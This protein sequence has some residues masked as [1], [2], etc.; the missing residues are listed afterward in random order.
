MNEGFCASIQ[1]WQ[2]LVGR[3]IL[4]FGD[5]ELLTYRIWRDRFSENPPQ[6]FG[7]RT[8][9]IIAHLDEAAQ[10]DRAL[11]ALLTKARELAKRRNVVA[12][13]PVQVQVFQHTATGKLYMENAIQC[14]KTH[15]L[16]DDLELMELASSAESIV[17]KLYIE[18]GYI[19]PYDS[20]PAIQADASGTT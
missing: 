19:A 18:L 12:H 6:R 20:Q 17:S 14:T 7:A 13:N 5:I 1:E 10:A 16:I 2:I 9:R 4:A 11:L 15:A 3:F 8:K